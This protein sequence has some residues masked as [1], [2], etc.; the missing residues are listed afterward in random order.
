M[1]NRR[2]IF[3]FAVLVIV[4]CGVFAGTVSAAPHHALPGALIPVLTDAAGPDNVTLIREALE[5]PGYLF[6]TGPSA[7]GPATGSVSPGGVMGMGIESIAIGPSDPF[8]AAVDAAADGETIWL[9]PGTYFVH[10]IVIAKN[11][12]IRSNASAGGSRANTILDAQEAGRIFNVTGAY[13]FALSDLTLQNGTAGWGGAIFAGAGSSLDATSV[14]FS[15]FSATGMI[16][17]STPT[18]TVSSGGAVFS[19]GDVAIMTSSFAGCSA[20]SGNSDV[21]GA[22]GGAIS[23]V[24]T[25]IT[26]SSFTGCYATVTGSGIM[27]VAS[28]GAVFSDTTSVSSSTFTDCS[29]TVTG[30]RDQG[31]AYGGAIYSDTTS[32]SSSSF[33]DC[34]ATVT[35]NGDLGIAYGGAI[36]STTTSVSLST[37]T[38]CSASVPSSGLMGVA[39][40]GAI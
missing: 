24:T 38:G 30:N 4:L 25:T 8:Q 29:A 1:G 36:R 15:D 27:G 12:T 5:D 6:R 26:S 39:Y 17:P 2:F 9:G 14:S 10:D 19:Y 40:G 20:T 16:N 18:T 34:S 37:F 28:G 22:L 33:T 11:L 32:F 23:A 3:S 21:T 35:V 31:I 7:A 13:R